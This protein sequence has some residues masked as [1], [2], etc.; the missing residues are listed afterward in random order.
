MTS[1]TRARALL[2][3]GLLAGGTMVMSAPLAVRAQQAAADDPRFTGKSDVLE[4]KDL[5]L[6]RRRFDPGARSAWHSHDK[7]QLIYV[8]EGR[9][10][11]QKKGQPIREFGVGDSEYTGPNVAHWHG[12]VPQTHFVQVA[13]GFGGDIKWME[14]VTDAEYAGKK[15]HAN[16][17]NQETATKSRNHE[18]GGCWT[19]RFRAFRVLRGVFL[20]ATGLDSRT[21]G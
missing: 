7:G 11:T 6:S 21:N 13:V 9:A 16:R 12:A 19:A 14:K 3:L 4:A 1:L 17:M 8:E 10:R 15:Y 18:T 20:S 5:S 2:G